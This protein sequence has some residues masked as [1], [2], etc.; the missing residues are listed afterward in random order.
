MAAVERFRKALSNQQVDENIITQIFYG[1]EP[2]SDKAS[3]NQKANF[4]VEAMKRIDVLLNAETC[5]AVRDACA[6][7]TGGWRLKA[8]QKLARDL[9]TS[10]I[11]EKI[12]ALNQITHMGKPK[13]NADGTITAHIGER[14]GFQCPCPV[15][16]G[17]EINEPV[18]IT[19]CYCCAGHF[20]YLYQIALGKKL[21]TKKVS[22]SALQSGSTQPCRFVY[23]I[24]E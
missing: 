3:K 13:L 8:V 14:G 1:F 4:F 6:C 9:A 22:S 24:I 11:P 5:H 23:T 18:S 10:R 21:I 2:I 19:Y 12:F 15:F 17:V 7:S 20:R 16:S